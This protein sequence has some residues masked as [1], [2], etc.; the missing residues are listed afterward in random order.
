M[1]E[2][3]TKAFED[4][5]ARF[6]ADEALMPLSRW[7]ESLFRFV[8]SR[9]VAER[10]PDVS[11]FF[12]CNQ[13]DLVLHRGSMR[14]LM[15]F[16]FYVHPIRYD[17]WSGIDLGWK[18]GPSE[19]NRQEF[20]GSLGK[21][22]RRCAPSR[23]LTVLKLLALVY[24]D[25]VTAKRRSYDTYYGNTSRDKAELN[26]WPLVSIGPFGLE[27]STTCHARLYEVGE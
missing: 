18:G 3:L 1:R 11:Q 26:I 8:Y 27:S 21:L 25:P 17:E 16:K 23:D 24:A 20:V 12:E 7:S 5:V 19:Q 9:A 4:A 14:A 22:R 15:E 13:I 2:L 10:A 6:K